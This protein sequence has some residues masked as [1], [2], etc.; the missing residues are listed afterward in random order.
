MF[1]SGFR[2]GSISRL[3]ASKLNVSRGIAWFVLPCLLCGVIIS[4]PIRRPAAA[5]SRS[6]RQLVLPQ[7]EELDPRV[8]FKPQSFVEMLA[9]PRWATPMFA[10]ITVNTLADDAVINS[11]CTLREAIIAANTNRA[12]DA[13]QPGAAGLDTIQFSLGA[14]TPAINLA[15]ALPTITEPVTING[16]TGGATR[17][18]LNGSA[19]GAAANGLT[20]TAGG[21]TIQR[22]IINR[23]SGGAGIR[24]QGG[25]GNA[26]QNCFVGTNAAGAAALPNNE[27]IRIEGSSGNTLTTNVISGNMQSG[28]A[29]N[30]A[31]ATGNQ[32]LGSRIGTDAT[33]LILPNGA[34]GIT[35]T[36]APGNTIGNTGPRN[37]I[38]GNGDAGIFMVGNGTSGNVGAGSPWNISGHCAGD[39][40]SYTMGFL[41]LFG[42]AVDCIPL[43]G[44]W[45]RRRRFESERSGGIIGV[46][47]QWHAPKS[48]S[49]ENQ[50]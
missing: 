48:R 17:I 13:C 3:I 23:F 31:T 29:I 36:D 28:V 41:T 22:L 34:S 14:G 50:E 20:I 16:N 24:L 30:N 11:N 25:M 49:D 40:H 2:S 45:V 5:D 6:N 10:T 33:G 35:I 8:A 7:R 37:V 47:A 38:S 18:E 39:R 1:N 4:L 43:Y 21:S 19:A 9:H 42:D 26:V 46:S 27:G 12:V 32:I 15:S 44:S